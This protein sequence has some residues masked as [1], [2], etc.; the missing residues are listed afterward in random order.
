MD[1]LTHSLLGLLLGRLVAPKDLR[2]RNWISVVAANS[3]DLDLLASPTKLAYLTAHRHLTHSIVAIPA[4]AACAVALVWWGDS[5]RRRRRPDRAGP[6]LDL[7]RAWLAALLPTA[8]HPLM[9]WMNSYAVRPWLP[10]SDEWSSANLLFVIDLWVWVLLGLAVFAPLVL[11]WGSLGRDRAALLALV[12]LAGYVGWQSE[13]TDRA[14]QAAVASAP[15]GFEAAAVFP[16]PLDAD[17]RIAFI[18]AGDT[19]FLDGVRYEKPSRRDLLDAAWATEVG[20]AYR[21]FSLYPLEWVEPNGEGWR[22]RF[23]D[24]RFMRLGRPG[25][26]CSFELDAEGRVLS[27]KF[28]F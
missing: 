8:S 1:N 10:F 12:A 19:K 28:E 2:R 14:R 15:A 9:D 24:A 3:P 6:P 11:R 4:M 20:Q 23:G 21:R 22:V 26:L 13:V 18:D 16:V 17:G 25:F 5:I 7:R 27:S